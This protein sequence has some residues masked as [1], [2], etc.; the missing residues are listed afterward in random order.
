MAFDDRGH[1][2][3][4]RLHY[5]EDA[6]AAPPGGT[7]AMAMFVHPVFPGP[8]RVPAVGFSS[9][10]VYTNTTP[11]GAY[12]GPWMMETLARERLIDIAA[13]RLG[14]DPIELRRRNVIR[15]D[16]LPYH[17][18]TGMVYDAI[19][20]AA[21]L[22]QAVAILDIETF[23]A[24]QA[25]AL[26]AGRYVGLGVSMF[27]EPTGVTAPML[28][29]MAA[30]MRVEL[31]GKVMVSMSTSSHG[32]SL[33]TT[34]PQLVADYLGVDVDDVSLIEGD[35]AV[36]PTGGGTG[37]S[38]MAVYTSGL[39]QAAADKLRTKIFAIAA[40]LLEAAT[41]DLVM[42]RG[43]VSVRGTPTR[44]VPLSR[45]AMV[46]L[47]DFA[48]LPADIEPGL[49]VTSRFKPSQP[50]TW[51]NAC[52][53][54]TC[55]IDP[56]TGQVTLLRYVVSEDCGVVINPMVVEGQIAGGV[57]Q[58]IGGAILEHF[59]HDDAGNPLTTTFLD[60]LCPTATEVPMI[61]YGHI[62]TPSSQP[63][64]VKGMGE[65]GAIGAPAAVL[66]AVADALVPLGVRAGS[67]TSPAS[68]SAVLDLIYRASYGG[69]V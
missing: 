10:T 69:D 24:E 40:E 1:I 27:V 64:G 65:G 23:R 49:E 48:R 3:G 51:S 28:P 56:R 45:I 8:Y 66:N 16:E 54:C 38:R 59:V 18:A 31:S 53:V 4:M 5:V 22:E 21:T 50:F 20:P 39:A 44:S 58:G 62:E 37:G 14:I 47:F 19:T 2:L 43:I 42:E 26:A 32:Q 68:P 60:Y 12:R 30:V 13:E 36:V 17:T 6:G 11:R 61:E 35:T 41:D 67:V 46:A 7:F 57:V 9:M 52:H 25:A 34:V 29:S 55:E 63:G 15:S 33:E